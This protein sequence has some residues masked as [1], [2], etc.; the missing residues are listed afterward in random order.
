MDK[1]YEWI[2]AYSSFIDKH[3]EWINA[4]SSFIDKHYEWINAYSSFTDKHYEWINVWLWIYCYKDPFKTTKSLLRA[5]ETLNLLENKI[6]ILLAI[7]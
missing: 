2:N 1:H 6:Y 7:A 3:Y 4:Y 5:H